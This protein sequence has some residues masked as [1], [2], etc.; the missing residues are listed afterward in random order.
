MNGHVN[1]LPG[2]P[3]CYVRLEVVLRERY[4]EGKS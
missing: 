1:A 4:A 3:A 2:V